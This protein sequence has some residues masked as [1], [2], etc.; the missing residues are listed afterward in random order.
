MAKG[1]IA[2]NKGSAETQKTRRNAPQDRLRRRVPLP[3]PPRRPPR[4]R[5][6]RRWARDASA[7]TPASANSAPCGRSPRR[8]V[9]VH[10]NVGTAPEPHLDAAADVSCST[11]PPQGCACTRSPSKTC[12]PQNTAPLRWPPPNQPAAFDVLVRDESSRRSPSR[13]DRADR[14]LPRDLPARALATSAISAHRTRPEDPSI[15]RGRRRPAVTE[16]GHESERAREAPIRQPAPV[17]AALPLRRHQIERCA[18]DSATSSRWRTFGR[19]PSQCSD[20]RNNSEQRRGSSSSRRSS[21][22]PFDV[23][24]WLFVVDGRRR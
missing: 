10:S 16:C 2:G 21:R 17:I 8:A 20:P 24:E 6:S 22:R 12:M 14:A 4:R 3:V 18:R 19:P 9:L 7:H 13:R 23:A 15:A 1:Q 5:L 11:R